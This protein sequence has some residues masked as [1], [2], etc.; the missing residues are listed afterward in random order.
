MLNKIKLTDQVRC[1]VLLETVGYQQ[2]KH[3]WNANFI[4]ASSRSVKNVVTGIQ[5]FPKIN[6]DFFSTNMNALN[7][8]GWQTVIICKY[9]LHPVLL[10]IFDEIYN[11]AALLPEPHWGH[12]TRSHS[13]VRVL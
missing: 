8:E 3:D 7:F 2:M 12:I 1:L 6:T 13:S 9:A 11:N 5:R 4:N 10:Q